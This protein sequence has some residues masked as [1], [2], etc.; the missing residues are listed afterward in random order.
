MAPREARGLR[1]DQQAAWPGEGSRKGEMS[2]GTK[3]LGKILKQGSKIAATST[4]FSR[5]SY[6]RLTMTQADSN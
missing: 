4:F 3:V 5:K 2:K 1:T 6:V